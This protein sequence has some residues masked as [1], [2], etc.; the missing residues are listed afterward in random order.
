MRVS[1]NT[2]V[3]HA[4]TADEVARLATPGA[5]VVVAVHGH[6]P[7]T[8]GAVAL[9]VVAACAGR[10]VNLGNAGVFPALPFTP[11]DARKTQRFQFPWPPDRGCQSVRE[12]TL[13]LLAEG[14]DGSGATFD[15]ESITVH[16]P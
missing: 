15:I 12:V 1:A 9:E 4:F 2:V 8:R 3:R 14:G 6:T 13:R 5:T 7:A 16:T 10:D 11:A